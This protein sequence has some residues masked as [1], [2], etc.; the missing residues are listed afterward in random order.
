MSNTNIRTMEYIG[1]DYWSNAVF[2]CV[3][4]DRLYKSESIQDLEGDTSRIALC[5]CGNDFHGEM[6]FPI[7]VKE[8]EQIIFTNI[9]KFPNREQRFN[10]M[11]LSRLQSDCD[12]YLGYGNR[13]AK[14]LWAGNEAEQI[15]KMRELW[16]G[17]DTDA[18]PEWLTMEQIEDYASKMIDAVVIEPKIKNCMCRYCKNYNDNNED[19]RYTANNQYCGQCNNYK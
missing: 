16:N 4:T 19:C 5:T 10:Y 15:D 7:T 8:N 2:K 9:P 18:K 3:E 17:F 1:E 13:N 14:Q 12:Y 11:L 6:G